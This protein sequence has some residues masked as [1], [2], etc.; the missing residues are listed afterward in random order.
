MN[1]ETGE[2][3]IKQGRGNH[4]RT[5]EGVGGKLLLTNKRLIFIPHY[6]NVQSEEESISLNEIVRAEAKGSDFLSRKISIY[7][8]N[9]S[10]Q[11]FFV[12]RRKNWVLQI[13]RAIKSLES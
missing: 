3:L 13:N 11:T 10:I 9:D 2:V 5:F 6:L 8:R 1:L 4:L 7:V 12:Y